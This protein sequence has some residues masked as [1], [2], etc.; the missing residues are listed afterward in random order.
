MPPAAPRPAQGRWC[1]VN[2]THVSLFCRIEQVAESTEG[3]VRPSR[4]HEQ[5]QVLGWDLDSLY[6]CF[7][8]NQ[9]ISLRPPL[10]RVLD[11][12]PSGC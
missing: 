10:V 9:V 4:L 8:D 3:T 12:A 7:T 1:D 6:V 2:G 5:G 11:T